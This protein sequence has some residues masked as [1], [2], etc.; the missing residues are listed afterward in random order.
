MRL[1]G[2]APNKIGSLSL[3]EES[4]ASKEVKL[5]LR[6][7]VLALEKQEKYISLTSS[8]SEH[9]KIIL[10]HNSKLNF[11]YYFVLSKTFMGK[12]KISKYILLTS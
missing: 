1:Q 9:L 7:S 3:K 11:S 8:S 6:P 12:L 4:Q 5:F 2:Q 10:A